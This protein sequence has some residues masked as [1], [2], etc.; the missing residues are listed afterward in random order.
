M[1]QINKLKGTLNKHQSETEK[2][3]NRDK[4]FKDENKKY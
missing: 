1:K 4:W 3:I 2:T